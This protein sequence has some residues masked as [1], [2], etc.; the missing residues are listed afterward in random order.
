MFF[1]VKSPKELF[2]IQEPTFFFFLNK[3]NGIFDHFESGFH[4]NHSSG[5]DDADLKS[6]TIFCCDVWRSAVTTLK[7]LSWWA[8]GPVQLV[9]DTRGCEWPFWWNAA[10]IWSK[11]YYYIEWLYS[12]SSEDFF[13]LSWL[14][15]LNFKED[16]RYLILVF[17]H[18]ET[19][20]LSETENKPKNQTC[21]SGLQWIYSPSAAKKSPTS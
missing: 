9:S 5:N 15:V 3:S 6:F 21:L 19:K 8:D 11:W 1:L 4:V 10:P 17:N 20:D 18:F 14:I 12:R 2:K 16:S 13:L 7:K